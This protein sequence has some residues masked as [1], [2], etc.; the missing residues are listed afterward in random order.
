MKRFYL[1]QLLPLM[2]LVGLLSACSPRPE[3]QLAEI[4]LPT[5]TT[6]VL[7]VTTPDWAATEATLQRM[8]KRADEWYKIVHL[9]DGFTRLH[10]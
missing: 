1:W 6:Q 9:L 10:G 7:L 4:N 3:Q 8:E 5:T 2:M